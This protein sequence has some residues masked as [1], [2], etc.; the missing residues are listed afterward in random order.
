[1]PRGCHSKGGSDA[2]HRVDILLDQH[3]ARFWLAY[4]VVKALFDSQRFGFEADTG[5]PAIVLPVYLA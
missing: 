4:P 5:F 3:S 1:M 2:L